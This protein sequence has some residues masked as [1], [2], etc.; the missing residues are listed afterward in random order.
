[1]NAE[2][3]PALVWAPDAR[4]A[5]EQETIYLRERLRARAETLVRDA[6][7]CDITLADVDQ[8]RRM[9]GHAPVA[10]PE[11][12]AEADW[13][14]TFGA[15]RVLDPAAPVAICTLASETL[16]DDLVQRQPAGVAIV[17]RLFTEN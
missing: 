13:P 7:R 1:M 16:V 9:G 6:G 8:A 5:I 12:V 17:G 2:P 10:P 15:Y 3:P 11:P 14:V 4:R